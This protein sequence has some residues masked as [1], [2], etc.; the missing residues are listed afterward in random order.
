MTDEGGSTTLVK[1]AEMVQPS[2]LARV[3]TWRLG[4]DIPKSLQSDVENIKANLER[5]GS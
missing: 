5:S 1:G 4:R 3:M 2:F